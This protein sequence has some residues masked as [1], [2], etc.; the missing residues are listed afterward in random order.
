MA[1]KEVLEIFANQL[2]LIADAESE[3]VIWLQ[4]IADNLSYVAVDDV[5]APVR[6]YRDTPVALTTENDD[7]EEEE[8]EE[9]DTEKVDLSA[10][11]YTPPRYPVVMVNDDSVVNAMCI[12]RTIVVYNLMVELFDYDPEKMAVIL[13]HEVAHSIQKHFVEQHGLASL[14]FMFTDIARSVL[15]VFTEAL[16]PHVNELITNSI[17]GAI[18]LETNRT[19]NRSLEKEVSFVYNQKMYV[20]I[21]IFLKG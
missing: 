16:G 10:Y 7:D 14:M 17:S 11:Q 2:G 18:S 5:R 12:G 20:L 19:Y 13:S 8:E 6:Q 3:K 4:T 15:W 1:H 9:D 21:D